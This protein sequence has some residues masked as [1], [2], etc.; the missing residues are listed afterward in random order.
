MEEGIIKQIKPTPWVSSAAYPR[1]LNG[2]VRVCLD[3]GNLNDETI[4][5]NHKPMT[6]EK[7]AH[8]MAGTTVYM[9]ADAL[10]TFSKIHCTKR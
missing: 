6:V 3:P 1:K 2:D 4:R 7:L 8:E 10:K 5:E 9:K